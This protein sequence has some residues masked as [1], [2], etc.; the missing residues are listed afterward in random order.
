[1]IKNGA[2]A[3]RKKNNVSKQL[4]LQENKNLAQNVHVLKMLYQRY[5]K[6]QNIVESNEHGK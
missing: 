5:K 4:R 2:I 1:M 3:T 6:I